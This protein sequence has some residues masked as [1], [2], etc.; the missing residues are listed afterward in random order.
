MTSFVFPPSSSLLAG[1]MDTVKILRLA[2]AAKTSHVSLDNCRNE[3]SLS[4][5]VKSK[6]QLD[7]PVNITFLTSWTLSKLRQRSPVNLLQYGWSIK[8]WG[9]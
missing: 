6:A 8:L 9:F 7:K 4:L 5:P 3:R 1:Q 2:L